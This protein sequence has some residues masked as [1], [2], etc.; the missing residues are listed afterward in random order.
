MKYSLAICLLIGNASL[1]SAMRLNQK[2]MPD[3]A[4]DD[5]LVKEVSKLTSISEE[6]EDMVNSLY[7]KE[8]E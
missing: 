8:Q 1:A 2:F 7:K 6:D 3:V 5:S 4:D